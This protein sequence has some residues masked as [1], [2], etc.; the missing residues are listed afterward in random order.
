MEKVGIATKISRH[1]PL[2]A[3]KIISSSISAPE[4]ELNLRKRIHFGSY[5]WFILIG[6]KTYDGRSLFYIWVTSWVVP[7]RAKEVGL[8]C[9]LLKFGF[10]DALNGLW[11]KYI[12]SDWNTLLTRVPPP[13]R[14]IMRGSFKL[15]CLLNKTFQSETCVQI[16]ASAI[17]LQTETE[18][19]NVD[20]LNLVDRLNNCIQF[21]IY[22]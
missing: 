10:P 15:L 12:N 18:R 4:L 14:Q 21:I 22:E 11:H 19:F 7:S 17:L 1:F 6:I 8:D 13:V 3:W 20:R 5:I 16:E 2:K 9:P